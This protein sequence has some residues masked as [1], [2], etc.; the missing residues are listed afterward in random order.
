MYGWD[1]FKV[2]DH[3]FPIGRP[4]FNTSPNMNMVELVLQIMRDIYI[5]VEEV[6]MYSIFCFPKGLLEMRNRGFMEVR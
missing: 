6:I 1:I 5:T 3:Y 4:E 2:R